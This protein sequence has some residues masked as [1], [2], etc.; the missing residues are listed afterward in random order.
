MTD[1]VQRSRFSLWMQAVRPF[2]FTASITPVLLGTALAFFEI[3]RLNG[4]FF[5]A[6][7]VG[8]MLLHAGTN[9]VAEFY[10]L[11]IGADRPET[12]GSSRVLVEGLMVPQDVLRGGLIAFGAAFL[13]GI[14]LVWHLG[15]PIVVL[16][17][18]GI[19][20]GYFYTGGFI[21][22]KYRALGEPFVFALMGP[23]MVFG[24]YYVQT[25]RFSWTPIL[26]SIPIGILVASILNGN[27][28]R[29][30]PDDYRAGFKTIPGKLGWPASARNYR[31]LIISAYVILVI[32]VATKVAPVW[33][34]IALLSIIPSLKLHKTVIS[35]RPLTPSDLAML[36][37]S[38]AQ[39]HF[40]FGLLL[41][42]GFIL[43]KFFCK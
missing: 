16:G 42:A 15:W 17:I 28:L 34:L 29:D 22:Y 41:T 26:V 24:A 25:E 33:G 3:G 9:L 35:A 27:N 20:G 12:F 4:L 36:D 19:L 38:T 1:T 6:A 31:M 23:L 10:D 32:L 14:Y 11:K 18:I 40:L 39:V 8:G 5:L 37:V 30:I 43:G 13:V 7:L 2:A 21:G